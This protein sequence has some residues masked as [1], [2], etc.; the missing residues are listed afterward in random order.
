MSSSLDRIVPDSTRGS[1]NSFDKCC[2]GRSCL[3]H[4]F[5]F[6]AVVVNCGGALPMH[7]DQP[8]GALRDWGG[9]ASPLAVH[10]RLKK[11]VA[12]HRQ[13]PLLAVR[14]RWQYIAVLLLAVR[15]HGSSSPIDVVGSSSPFVVFGSVETGSRSLVLG[16]E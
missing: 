1:P 3:L 13:L 10:R 15:R 5:G 12:V 7:D 2:R 4:G 6:D 9:S 14:R 16:E 11:R 8:V